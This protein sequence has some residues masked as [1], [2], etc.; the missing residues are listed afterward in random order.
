MVPR[1]RV[2]YSFLYGQGSEV[3][4]AFV[5]RYLNRA[6]G[7]LALSRIMVPIAHVEP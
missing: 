5:V 2:V 6:E 7:T 3:V 1:E 4:Q